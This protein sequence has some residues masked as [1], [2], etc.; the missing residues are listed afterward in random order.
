MSKRIFKNVDFEKDQVFISATGRLKTNSRPTL[1]IGLGGT[2]A[3]AVLKA[4]K[5]IY[6]RS[7]LSDST[8]ARPDN[9][10]YLVIDTD[11]ATE[12]IDYEGTI[13][14]KK[15]SE[16]L[17]IRNADLIH[18]IEEIRNRKNTNN[19]SP[20]N[21]KLYDNIAGWLSDD[22]PA[23]R[24]VNGAAG[25]RQAGR[26]ILFLNMIKI[27]NA[28]SDKLKKIARGKSLAEIEI[29][30]YV[31]FG[32]GGGTGSGTFIDI[33]YLI[34]KLIYDMGGNPNINGMVFLPDVSLLKPGIDLIS[35]NNIKLN[36]YAALL[37]LDYFM[38]MD[39]RKKVET[40]YD[41]TQKYGDILNVKWDKNIFERCFLF[42]AS[43]ESR[44]LSYP[45][46]E[47]ALIAAA[48]AIWEIIADNRSGFNVNSFFSNT[49]P[50]VDDF[51]INSSNTSLCY[52][53]RK[54]TIV[55]SG[56]YVFPYNEITTYFLNQI[57]KR[58]DE[59]NHQNPYRIE[60]LL[61]LFKLSNKN[62]E[63]LFRSSNSLFKTKAVVDEIRIK[64]IEKEYKEM[65]D[66]DSKQIREIYISFGPAVL[67]DC[68]GQIIKQCDLIIDNKKIKLSSQE[69]KALNDFISKLQKHIKVLKQ[70]IDQKDKIIINEITETFL[71]FETIKD[72]NRNKIDEINRQ[73]VFRLVTPK[74]LLE[75][76]E[77]EQI[78]DKAFYQNTTQKLYENVLEN[79]D[80]WFGNSTIN[81]QKFASLFF[82]ELFEKHINKAVDIYIDRN[83]DI[84]ENKA[85]ALFDR[86]KLQFPFS[87]NYNS[88]ESGEIFS[89]F[90]KAPTKLDS[91]FKGTSLTDKQNINYH[92]YD[93][94]NR[95]SQITF[96][97]NLSLEDYFEF[98]NLIKYSEDFYQN[99]GKNKT[100]RHYCKDFEV[101]YGK[102]RK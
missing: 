14:E 5:M 90:V 37:E 73:I 21:N 95:I 29:D 79:I 76:I 43:D 59:N 84:I 100:E 8:A 22:I 64:S 10:E 101:E 45:P 63:Q 26:L 54:Y 32:V 50:H 25:I 102:I 49:I 20:K 67:S 87:I 62:L 9:F 98:D 47:M 94:K 69:K 11:T 97:V 74:Q 12:N 48:E 86:S 51:Y 17:L 75:I 92:T 57:S 55:G 72:D 13:L 93:A 6:E 19:A 99:S 85:E 81:P 39:R 70:S 36:G 15:Y 89:T 35:K 40:N 91:I 38:E 30:V 80:S 27:R 78:I 2:G 66:R 88:V 65:F 68:L 7:E 16:F 18:I 42:G 3:A 34:R 52:K 31:M 33:S 4:K 41:Y 1:V 83:K 82:K 46:D 58:I 56:A 77:K 61:K 24:I 28:L 96:Q 44:R 71:N 23:S 53:S 60:A